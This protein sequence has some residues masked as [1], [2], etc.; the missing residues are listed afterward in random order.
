LLV[1]LGILMTLALPSTASGWEQFY[2]SHKSFGA[3]GI[4]LSA[5]NQNVAWNE[6][7]WV[8]YAAM[9][10]TLCNSS[11]QCYDYL[12]DSDGFMQDPRSISYGRAKCNAVGDVFIW[13][14]YTTNFS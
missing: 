1:V 10:T 3:G 8:A 9:R 13:Y 14:C 6:V 5:F 11:Y 4:G 7:Y 2:V 12:P